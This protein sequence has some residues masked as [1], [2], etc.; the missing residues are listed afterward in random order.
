MR[1]RDILKEEANCNYGALRK[2]AR[3]VTQ[4]YDRHLADAGVTIGQF[5]I[6]AEVARLS[7]DSG[8]TVT[9]LAE[10]L[11]MDRTGLAH[12]LKPMV[13]DGLLKLTVDRIDRRVRRI[14]LTPRGRERLQKAYASWARAQ[15]RFSDEF[16]VDQAVAL[17]ALLRIVAET[18]F[19]NASD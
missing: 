3:R 1:E 2:A 18:D 8:P 7:D 19:G 9:Q 6:L 5:S 11:V 15:A 12:T 16:G 13:R 14:Q 4:L 17:R 10:S